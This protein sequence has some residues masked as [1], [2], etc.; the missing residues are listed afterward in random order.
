MAIVMEQL[1]SRFTKTSI[2]SGKE[3]ENK[4]QSPVFKEKSSQLGPNSKTYWKQQQQ[5]QE[6]GKLSNLTV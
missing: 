6:T 5:Q 1:Q 4:R 3:M 2:S